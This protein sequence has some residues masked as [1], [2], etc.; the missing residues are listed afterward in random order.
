MTEVKALDSTNHGKFAKF[1]VIAPQLHDVLER[2]VTAQRSSVGADEI[3]RNSLEAI[4][5]LPIAVI[6]APLR[7]VAGH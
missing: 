3:A 4:V 5:K 2:G 7:A 6:S 1:A